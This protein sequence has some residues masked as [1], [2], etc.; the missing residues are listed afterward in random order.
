MWNIP[1]ACKLQKIHIF[2]SNATE[3]TDNNRA[4][5]S[6]HTYMLQFQK[7]STHVFPS[8]IMGPSFFCS[9]LLLVGVGW[10]SSVLL[11]FLITSVHFSSVSFIVLCNFYE[12]SRKYK[13][14]LLPKWKNTQPYITAF[15]INETLMPQCKLALIRRT[16]ALTSVSGTHPVVLSSKMV[17]MIFKYPEIQGF[18]FHFSCGNIIVDTQ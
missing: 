4:L 8:C 13:I 12:S 17:Q 6:Q 14:L 11:L 5:R 9:Y 18:P 7:A 1:P 15:Y 3:S 2:R 16:N 10:V